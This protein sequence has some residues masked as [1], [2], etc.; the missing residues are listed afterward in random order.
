[1]NRLNA[2]G[3]RPFGTAVHKIA[4]DPCKGQVHSGGD[5]VLQKRICGCSISA[6]AGTTIHLVTAVA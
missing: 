6:L 3:V 5:K 2:V 4:A 1:M